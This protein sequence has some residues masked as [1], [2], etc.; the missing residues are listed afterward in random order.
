M[1]KVVYN[2][3]CAACHQVDGRGIPAAFPPLANSDYLNAD[4]TRAIRVVK[5]GLAGE[6]VVNK[7]KYNSVMPAL[8]PWPELLER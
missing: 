7:E 2:Q 4:K 3:N 8:T 6:V 5:G 1:G